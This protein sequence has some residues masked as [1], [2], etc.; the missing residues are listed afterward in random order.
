MVA[1]RLGLALLVIVCYLMIAGVCEAQEYSFTPFRPNV[2]QEGFY[3]ELGLRKY[4]NSFTSYQ[5]PNWGT[6]GLGTP[7]T[8]D[9]LSRL[10]HPW[11]TVWGLVRLGTNLK[12]VDLKLEFASSLSSW[13]NLK[14]QDSDWSDANNPG[15]KTTFSESIC[16]PNGWTLDISAAAPL[17]HAPKLCAVIGF[18]QQ[19]FKF[20]SYDFLQ[21]NIW[22]NN[23]YVPTE[24][25]QGNGPTGSFTQYYQQYYFG[26]VAQG[27][28][29]LGLFS[30][31][32]FS[33]SL[34]VKL[35][36]DYAS[37]RGKNYDV[38]FL[39]AGMGTVDDTNGQALHLNLTTGLYI[40]NRLRVDLEGD[41]M[42]IRTDGTYTAYSFPYTIGGAKVW[43]DQQYVSLSGRYTF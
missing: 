30:E 16:S 3:A 40:G 29:P 18:R 21:G 11:D 5:F 14:V 33:T 4:I 34:L 22:K 28:M 20:D 8:Q 32:L 26:G 36:C 2:G 23:G 38:H 12:T 19:E 6:S 7:V 13:T 35:Q 1:R 31:S 15:Q 39:R 37:V 42:R 10:E 24:T 9:P 43:S 17:P 41:F 25:L 27:V